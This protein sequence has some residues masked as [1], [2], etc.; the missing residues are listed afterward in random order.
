MDAA[1]GTL[2]GV[3]GAGEEQIHAARRQRR[4]QV[5]GV[6]FHHAVA[7]HLPQPKIGRGRRRDEGVSRRI[8][9]GLKSAAGRRHSRAGMGAWRAR[10][11]QTLRDVAEAEF[12]ALATVAGRGRLESGE[13]LGQPD[14]ADLLRGQNSAHGQV[15][16]RQVVHLAIVSDEQETRHLPQEEPVM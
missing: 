1:V 13:L 8:G 5:E 6:A 4:D 11:L 10:A 2:I 12:R 14:P 15:I 16:R 7:K 3:R 9:H